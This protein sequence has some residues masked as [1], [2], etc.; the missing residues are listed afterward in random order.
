MMA[1]MKKVLSPNS[2]TTITDKDAIN[3]WM[4]PKSTFPPTEVPVMAPPSAG[5]T[6]YK[7]KNKS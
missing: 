7:N 5:V 3:A 1:A 2:E 4:N 6:F